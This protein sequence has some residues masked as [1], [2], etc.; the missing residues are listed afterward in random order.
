MHAQAVTQARVSTVHR[1][2]LAVPAACNETQ[3]LPLCLSLPVHCC[4]ALPCPHPTL[5]HPAVPLNTA[6]PCPVLPL[7]Y[8]HSK[9]Q[10]CGSDAGSLRCA[11]C[12]TPLLVLGTVRS[13]CGPVSPRPDEGDDVLGGRERPGS[14]GRRGNT[15]AQASGQCGAH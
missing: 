4:H 10:R 2:L 8:T 9:W 5:L 3:L 11:L 7:S 13:W 6:L 15:Y 14:G 12:V 1:T